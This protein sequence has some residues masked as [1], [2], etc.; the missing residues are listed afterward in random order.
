MEEELI[1]IVKDKMMGTALL[2]HSDMNRCGPL[3]TDIRDHCGYSI[4]VYPKTL[5]SGHNMLEDYARSRKL[6]PKENKSKTS[7]DKNKDRKSSDESTGDIYNQEKLSP[8]TN[9]KMH[10]ATKCHN[11]EKFGH[12]TSHCP[13]NRGQQNMNVEDHHADKDEETEEDEG[14]QNLQIQDMIEDGDSAASDEPYLVNFSDFQFLQDKMTTSRYNIAA[15]EIK[16]NESKRKR[17][18]PKDT[19]SLLYGC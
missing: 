8:G 15:K 19:K 11:C 16:E 17:Y 13:D 9:G 2:K 14:V 10:P 1:N 18:P 7:E 3:M 12:Y 6:Y 4:A 5:A